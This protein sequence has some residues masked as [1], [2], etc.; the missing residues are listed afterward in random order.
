MFAKTVDVASVD[1]VG[2]DVFRNSPVDSAIVAEFED[3]PV[4]LTRAE[5]VGEAVGMALDGRL[6]ALMISAA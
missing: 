3:I 2:M 5:L 4:D 1:E 6:S